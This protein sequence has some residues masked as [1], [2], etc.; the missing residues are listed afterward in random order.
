MIND[1]FKIAYDLFPAKEIPFMESAKTIARR[2]RPYEG[3]K[4]VQNL[5]I[6]TEALHK[7]HVLYLGG[8]DITTTCPSFMDPKHEALS[9]LKAAGLRVSTFDDLPDDFDIVLDCAAE[10]L[11]RVTPKMGAVELTG[12]GSNIYAETPNLNYPVIS[13]DQSRVKVLEALFGTGDAFQRAFTTLT[14]ED[15]HGRDVLLFGYGKVGQGIAYA[16]R[17]YGCRVTVVD[18]NPAALDIARRHGHK[19][20]PSVDTVAVEQAAA[21]SFVVVTATGRAGLVS[22]HYASEPFLKAAYLANMGAEDEFGADFAAEA[23]MVN[24]KPINF[25]IDHPTRIRFLDPI[26]HAHHMGIELLRN[27]D[28]TPGL[29]AFPDFMAEQIIA[30]WEVH[31]DINVEKALWADQTEVLGG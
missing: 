27:F 30:E 29:H 12:T 2:T 8:A 26:F 9:V 7:I 20:I 13:V 10:L 25:A 16:L 18:T 21:A 3:L 24:K 19:A 28:F 1:P 17:P 15:L 6:T 5:P 11:G 22:K 14:G 31:F 23:V 4:I